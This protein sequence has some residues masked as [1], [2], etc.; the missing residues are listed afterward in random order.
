[1]PCWGR[2]LRAAAVPKFKRVLASPSFFPVWLAAA[3][4]RVLPEASEGG[5][6]ELST[7][8]ENVREISLTCSWGPKELGGREEGV[9]KSVL[10]LVSPHLLPINHSNGNIIFAEKGKKKTSLINV[11]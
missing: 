11:W 5:G 9:I 4:P 10:T 2:R 8:P 7:F 3:P 6:G 1:M